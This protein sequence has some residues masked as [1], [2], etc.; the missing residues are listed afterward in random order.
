MANSIS[1]YIRS[2]A[3]AG[4]LSVEARAKPLALF[5]DSEA[6]ITFLWCYDEYS[7][8][9]PRI[10]IQLTFYILVVSYWGLRPGEIVESSVHRGSNEGF[11]YKDVAMSLVRY[12]QTL[13][14]QLSITLRNRKFKRGQKSNVYAALRILIQRRH[15]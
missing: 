10:R 5:V 6:I 8:T 3:A 12:Q 7:Y 4:A 11:K 14:Y 15:D 1:Q 9:H 2:L 13:R